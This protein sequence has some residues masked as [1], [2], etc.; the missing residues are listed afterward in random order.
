MQFFV[1]GMVGE[2]RHIAEDDQLHPGTRHGHIHPAQII[3]ESDLPR[4]VG[5]HQADEN[6]VPFLPLKTIYRVDTDG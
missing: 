3:Q 1:E 4:L 2:R 5:T 6:D